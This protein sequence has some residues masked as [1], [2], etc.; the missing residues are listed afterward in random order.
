M[1]ESQAFLNYLSYYSKF[2][3]G[4]VLLALFNFQC[5]VQLPLALPPCSRPVSG[6][7]HRRILSLTRLFHFVKHFMFTNFW[8]VILSVRSRCVSNET[9]NLTYPSLVVKRLYLP[10]HVTS[11]WYVKF[12]LISQGSWYH[13]CYRFVNCISDSFN[14]L[15][16]Y[17]M[18]VNTLCIPFF[19]L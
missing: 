8:R 5:P 16:R 6:P 3:N 19:I 15:P 1:V 9:L 18:F 2:I 10:I 14:I 13:W 17:F 4:F 7:S 11:A 12:R